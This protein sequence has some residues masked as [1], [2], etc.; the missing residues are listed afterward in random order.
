MFFFVTKIRF[1]TLATKII[2]K[3]VD[4]FGSNGRA[5]YIFKTHLYSLK[6]A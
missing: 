3:S 2:K 5:I 4:L 1:V 6:Q